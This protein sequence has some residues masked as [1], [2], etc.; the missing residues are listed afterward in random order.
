MG[1]GG[2]GSGGIRFTLSDPLAGSV[3]L[4]GDFNGWNGTA[5]PMTAKDGVW[6]VVVKFPEGQHQ[7]KFVVD[8]QW[9]ADPDNPVTA[10]DFGNSVVQVDAKGQVVAMKATSNT[11][12]SPKIYLDGRYYTLMKL[13]RDPIANPRWDLERPNFIFDLNLGIRVNDIVSARVLTT[14]NN[15]GQNVQLWE[16]NLAFNR[17][18]L[19][20]DS[21][22]LFVSAFDNDSTGTWED[23]L[24]L[25][26]GFGIYEYA[27]G[28]DQQGLYTYKD[29]GDY[30]VRLLYSDN[31]RTGG[32]VSPSLESS[33]EDLGERFL[34]DPGGTTASY[35][36]NDSDNNKDV[37]AVRVNGPLL[38]DKLTGGLAY[39]NDR[40]RNPGVYTEIAERE[41]LDDTTL[42]LKTNAYGGTVEN[43]Q[44]GGLDFSYYDDPAGIELWG[45]ALYGEAWM[46]GGV[47]NVLQMTA[48][49][50]DVELGEIHPDSIETVVLGSAPE[51]NPVINQGWRGLLGVHYFAYR[52]WHW[53]GFVRYA[54]L[55]ITPPDDT[56]PRENRENVYGLSLEFNGPEW[57]EWS[58]TASLGFTYH[59]F[60][61][62]DEAAWTDQFWFN[63]ENFWLEQGYNVSGN[64]VTN[65]VSVDRFVMLGGSDMLQWKPQ[66]SWTFDD[67][68]NATVRYDGLINQI[69]MGRKPKYWENRFGLTYDL[70]PRLTF[71]YDGRVVTYDDPVLGLNETFVSNFLELKYHFTPQIHVDLSWGVDPYVLDPFRWEFYYQGR[72]VFLFQNG[73]TADAAKD[74]FLDMGQTILNAERSLEKEQRIQLEAFLIF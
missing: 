68:H 47:G 56:A 64:D 39:R 41:L 62:A 18:N 34:M 17:G 10:G 55:D 19:T 15:Q 33:L 5:N 61:Y 50:I 6:S 37:F 52:G 58:W 66:A 3:H 48:S 20:L 23:P 22:D 35:S 70:N 26:G 44:G 29:L 13:Q 49:G 16:T 32:T 38:S 1:R 72:D 7:Y 67:D 57:K 74:S 24:H 4:A 11:E 30:R 2:R 53:K 51:F 54:N 69:S 42:R 71:G 28:Y 43:W 59:D 9:I 60:D 8:G 12:L 14:L 25:V 45:E 73:V 36:T 21:P 63:T 46:S 27:W 65:L 31:F 40:G